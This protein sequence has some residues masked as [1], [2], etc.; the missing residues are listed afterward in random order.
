MGVYINAKTASDKSRLIETLR[1]E[2]DRERSVAG[3][4]RTAGE[5]RV[6]G[7]PSREWRNHG[8]AGRVIHYR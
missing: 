6:N 7:T 8:S 5:S 4:T 2:L 1:N 3:G